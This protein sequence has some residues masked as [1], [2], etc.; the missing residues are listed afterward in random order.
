MYVCMAISAGVRS[1]GISVSASV[2]P[3]PP[4]SP[5]VAAPVSPCLQVKGKKFKMNARPSHF[6]VH[7]I[8]PK[9]LKVLADPLAEPPLA[10]SAS[11]EEEG[12]AALPQHGEEERE[13]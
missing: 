13:E 4:P 10:S 8:M 3:A 11:A 2:R 1:I 6:R 9:Q 12:L 7:A 5:L